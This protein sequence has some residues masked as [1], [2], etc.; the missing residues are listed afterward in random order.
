VFLSV[1]MTRSQSRRLFFL[2]Y[3]FV[4]YFKYLL[5]KG[6]W[7]ET[8][9]LAC[10]REMLTLFP[11]TPVLPLTFTRSWRNFSKMA[12]SRRPSSTGAERFK[13]NFKVWAF[14][15]RGLREALDLGLEAF[16][17]TAPAAGAAAAG[18]GAALAF[19][20][21][22][23]KR[24]GERKSGLLPAAKFSDCNA[25]LFHGEISW[26][27]FKI[28]DILFRFVQESETQQGV[29]TDNEHHRPRCRLLRLRSP[30]PFLTQMK[31]NC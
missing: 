13:V 8:V 16:A 31:I 28:Q 18:A 9:S 21:A 6:G 15:P 19:V 25:K 1:E 2:R 29:R 17:L 4:R 30:F 12:G 5:E 23:E 20:I 27:T 26:I 14:F 3:F 7:A 10:W 11:K 22:R 24:E